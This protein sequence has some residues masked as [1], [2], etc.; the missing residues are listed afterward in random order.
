MYLVTFIYKIL[1][2][3]DKYMCQNP[4]GSSVTS[5]LS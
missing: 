2:F 4:F 1:S 3:R 5:K